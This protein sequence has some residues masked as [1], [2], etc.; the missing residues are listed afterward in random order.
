[1]ESLNYLK[2]TLKLLL[3]FMVCPEKQMTQ[4]G[5]NGKNKVN[6]HYNLILFVL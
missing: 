4:K 3:N 6:M 5:E 2:E 1:M